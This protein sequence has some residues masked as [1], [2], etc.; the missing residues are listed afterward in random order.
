MFKAL[1]LVCDKELTITKED[2]VRQ[3]QE[4]LFLSLDID[5]GSRFEHMKKCVSPGYEGGFLTKLLFCN[6]ITAFLCDECFEKK[7]KQCYG[8]KIEVKR[9]YED[10]FPPGE[11]GV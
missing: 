2:G 9:T 11:D 5:E 4:G 10:I 7:H 3:V 6:T 1:C 8:T